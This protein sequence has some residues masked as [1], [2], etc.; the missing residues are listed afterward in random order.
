MWL[1][2]WHL[3]WSRLKYE[4]KKRRSGTETYK[5]KTTFKDFLPYIQN[6]VIYHFNLDSKFIRFSFFNNFVIYER[7]LIFDFSRKDYIIPGM[8]MF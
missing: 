2:L 5:E 8:L 7:T 4:V 3:I 1:A 6:Y